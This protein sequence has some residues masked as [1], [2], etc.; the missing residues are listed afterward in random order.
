MKRR[1]PERSARLPPCNKAFFDRSLFQYRQNVG[2]TVGIDKGKMRADY[3]RHF[4]YYALFRERL[5]ALGDEESL[6][7]VG[8]VEAFVCVGGRITLAAAP[9][10]GRLF[11]RP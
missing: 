4:V 5:Q 10:V 2:N 1:T 7:R 11:R 8:R 9:G 6:R 3:Q